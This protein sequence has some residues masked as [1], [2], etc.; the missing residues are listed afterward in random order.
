MT[1]GSSAIGRPL[2]A[3]AHWQWLDE[4]GSDELRERSLLAR[5][6]L[7]ETEGEMQRALVL[8]EG[9]ASRFPEG[10]HALEARLGKARVL[11][12]QGQTAEAL[13]AYETSLLRFP[14]DP[15]AP[16]VRLHIQKLRH[17]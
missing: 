3:N 10:R 1:P 9:M 5:A 16:Q 11:A 15:R 2:G 7:R 4:R 17:L 13:K 12:Q 6:A 8:Y 14:E